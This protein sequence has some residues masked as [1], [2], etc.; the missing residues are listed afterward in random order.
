MVRGLDWF[1]AF[2]SRTDIRFR[3]VHLAICIFFGRRSMRHEAYYCIR[4]SGDRLVMWSG[5]KDRQ[6]EGFPLGYPAAGVW[7]RE[8][9][10][11]L[12]GEGSGETSEQGRRDCGVG[13]SSAGAG[14]E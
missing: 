3:F 14:P 4:Y 10:A 12:P 1:I 8:Q 5:G 2:V 7:F 13:I 11:G 6:L 9:I